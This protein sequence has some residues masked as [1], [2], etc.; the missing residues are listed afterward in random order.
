MIEFASVRYEHR[1]VRYMVADVMKDDCEFP[2][3]FDK[4]FSLH[5]LHWIADQRYE[6][7]S[8]T[9]QGIFSLL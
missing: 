2:C 9:L 6:M 7:K 3:Q 1:D 4:I 8:L 5:V